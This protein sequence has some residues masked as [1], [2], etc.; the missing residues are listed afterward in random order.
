[1]RCSKGIFISAD[2]DSEI[3]FQIVHIVTCEDFAVCVTFF[4]HLYVFKLVLLSY[5]DEE[6]SNN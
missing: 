6:P 2:L 5:R 3:P 1:L 4:I